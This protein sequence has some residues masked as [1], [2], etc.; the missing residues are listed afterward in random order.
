MVDCV[1]GSGKLNIMKTPETPLPQVDNSATDLPR[2]DL[3]PTS[4][5]PPPN[6]DT[7]NTTSVLDMD[8]SS[9]N[10]SSGSVDSGG[11]GY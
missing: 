8:D 1:R 7:D 10:N 11:Y 9:D 5:T 6:T 3:R 4:S 2:R